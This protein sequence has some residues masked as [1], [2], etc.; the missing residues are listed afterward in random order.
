MSTPQLS[1][2]CGCQTAVSELT[3]KVGKKGLSTY[4]VVPC[5]PSV[6]SVQQSAVAMYIPHSLRP[7]SGTYRVLPPVHKKGLKHGYVTLP[8][9]GEA[10]SA[11]NRTK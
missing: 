4:L 11:M 8:L 7:L 9:H 3:R 5:Y 6:C 10:R 2:R 1:Q